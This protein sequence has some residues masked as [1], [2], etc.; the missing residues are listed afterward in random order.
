M[1]EKKICLFL[2]VLLFIFTLPVEAGVEEEVK[3]VIL[4]TDRGWV[5]DSMGVIT[6]LGDK[7]V[8]VPA[9]LVSPTELRRDAVLGFTTSQLITEV[10]KYSIGKTRPNTGRREFAPFSG[11]RSFPSGHAAGSFAFAT[12][13]AEHYPDYKFVAYATATLIAASRL[14]ENKH[15]VSDVVVGSAIGHYTTKY[16]V[17]TWKW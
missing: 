17:H 4:K 9:M 10:L 6:H 2:V 7:E 13:I 1:K 14:Y 15:W 5:D 3:E 16:M 12:A 11:H 8:I